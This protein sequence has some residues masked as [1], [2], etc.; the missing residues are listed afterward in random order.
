VWDVSPSTDWQRLAYAHA[1]WMQP[2]GM[3]D[4]LS[5][6][7][8]RQLAARVGL[9][10]EV[11]R[12]GGFSCS[13]M[14]FV[15]CVARLYVADVSDRTERAVATRATPR[16][17]P[18]LAGWRVRWLGDGSALL[19]GIAPRGSQDH[20]PPTHWI[21]VDPESG[22]VRDTIGATDTAGI[23][24]V[25][26]SEGPM[27]SYGLALDLASRSELEIDGA[28]IVSEGGWI[29]VSWQGP[30]GMGQHFRVG[31]GRALAATRGGRFIVAIVPGR[32]PPEWEYAYDLVVYH[33]SR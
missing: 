1:F 31:S 14:T 17:L 29:H 27:L 28:R 11:V 23:A 10:P 9:E 3:A 8:W 33:V 2:S 6:V 24:R 7:Q 12:R 16:P 18:V 4:S 26:W 5:D 30:G 21:V 15:Y 25:A 32:A 22:T 13:G 19:A 20:A